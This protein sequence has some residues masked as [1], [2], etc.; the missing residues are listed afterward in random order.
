MAAV[1]STP[2]P[3]TSE[4]SPA[5][6]YPCQE[7]GKFNL[8]HDFFC[9]FSKG[10]TI[11]YVQHNQHGINCR[12]SITFAKHNNSTS[13]MVGDTQPSSSMNF[14]CL[15]TCDLTEHGI[16]VNHNFEA[17]FFSLFSQAATVSSN[18]TVNWTDTST[19][20]QVRKETSCQNSPMIP[21]ELKRRKFLYSAH[22]R[23][24]LLHFDIFLPGE[25]PY[26]CSFEGCGYR[27]AQSGNLH[28][29]ELSH[30][31]WYL[32]N[33]T[34]FPCWFFSSPNLQ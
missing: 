34:F 32:C 27:S 1:A 23:L 9:S 20:I 33:K 24:V 4:L 26:E 13:S 10:F 21:G 12:K 18:G 17:I 31:G 3:S 11:F 30:T 22:I 25:K 14:S 16:T 6:T 19:F 2:E 29:H 5:R 15:C 8:E 28:V 7:P